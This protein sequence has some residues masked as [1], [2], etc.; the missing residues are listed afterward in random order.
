MARRAR[1][2]FVMRRGGE[3]RETQWISAAMTA[4]TL[5]A[6]STAALTG[7]LNAAALALRPFTIVR[8]RG[9]WHV[10]SDQIAAS[11]IWGA[12]LAWAVVSTEAS[13]IG[14]TAVPTPETDRGSDNF[15]VYETMMGRISEQGA[16]AA[17]FSFIEQG[18]G[19]AFDSKAMRK[20]NNDQDVVIVVETP[21]I[22]PSAAIIE[23]ARFL[24]KLH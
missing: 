14:V 20:V 17:G 18:Q 7:V 4:T 24:I 9:F 12:A 16:L 2:G 23:G 8:V 15:F 3:R 13:A 5:A 22:S 21:S 19:Q 1:A 6:A 10:R 11:E